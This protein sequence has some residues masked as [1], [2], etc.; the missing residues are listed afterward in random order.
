MR[1]GFAASLACLLL[2]GP[3][4]LAAPVVNLPPLTVRLLPGTD[5]GVL[6][7]LLHVR[8]VKGSQPA[9]LQ[10]DMA[11]K[12]VLNGA[13]RVVAG[14]DAVRPLYLQSVV[15]KWRYVACLEILARA[16]PQAIYSEWGEASGS[17]RQAPR[18]WVGGTDAFFMIPDVSP[19]R[20]LL[21]FGIGPSGDINLLGTRRMSGE[22]SGDTRIVQA[23]AIPPF[24]AEHLVA[25]TAAD[26]EG[27]RGLEVWLAETTNG[28]GQIDT[29]G[30]ILKQIMALK[31]VRIGL[32][33]SYSCR[34]APECVQ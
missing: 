34:T 26:P 5:P 20:Q 30:E 22:G 15:D 8:P 33:A 29:Q 9:V 31:E 7:E 3:P 12:R 4:L 18:A 16:H 25:V 23:G 19:S 28:H 2:A 10:I 13:G 27:M 17:T 21:V 11:H 14:P 6:R 1:I 32:L 24:G